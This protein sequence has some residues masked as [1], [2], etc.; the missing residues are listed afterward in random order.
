VDLAYEKGLLLLGAGENTIR[1]APPL[2]IDEEQAA[3]AAK[4]L[5]SCISEVEKTV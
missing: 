3:F 4:T 5:E 2:L 1:I